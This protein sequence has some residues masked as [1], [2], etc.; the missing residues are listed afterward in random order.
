MKYSRIFLLASIPVLIFNLYSVISGISWGIN[1]SDFFILLVLFSG[2]RKRLNLKNLNL[3]A[4]LL[5]TIA[6]ELLGFL[7]DLKFV[8]L[9]SVFFS[10]AS[11]FFLYREALTYTRRETANK[12]I[13]GFFIALIAANAY[14]LL[15]HLQEIEQH[16]KGMVEFSF[17]SLYYIN[18][19]VLGVV[20]L[21][22]YLNSYSRK[23]VFFISLVMAI[24]F[25]DVFRDMEK[26]YMADTSVLLTEYLLKYGGFILAFQFFATKEKKLRLINLV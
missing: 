6:A 13:L 26:F 3:L 16:V 25:S 19:M 24:I 20:G 17:Y 5:F 23:S 10:M 22:Y 14:F 15:S 7:K 11:Y 4:F 1:L 2:F 21:I 12:F 8:Y 18:L 9:I